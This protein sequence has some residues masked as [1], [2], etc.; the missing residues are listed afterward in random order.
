MQAAGDLD[1]VHLVVERSKDL[2]QLRYGFAI[3]SPGYTHEQGSACAHHV[4][5]I[6]SRRLAKKRE[7]AI[8]GESRGKAISLGTPA[9]RPH[10]GD[11]RDLVNNHSRV[12]N[13]DTIRE[14]GFGGQGND[15]STEFMETLLVSSVLSARLCYVD[16]MSLVKGQLTLVY[17]RADLAGDGL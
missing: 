5:A 13:K 2:A 4:T 12:F 16:G 10:D 8:V 14:I 6:Q 1:G 9:G 7:V 17:A 11:D 3:G 15:A